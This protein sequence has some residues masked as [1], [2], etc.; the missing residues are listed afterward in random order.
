MSGYAERRGQLLAAFGERPRG[1]I[2]LAKNTSNL[3]RDRARAGKHLLDV[4]DFDHVLAIDPAGHW[5]EAEGMT[6]YEDLAARTLA[7]GVMPAVVPQLKT[8][9]LGGAAAGVGIEASSFRHGLVHESLLEMDVLTGDGRVLT[10]TPDNEHRDLFFGFPNSYGTL[11]Y[12]LKLRA[13]TV[14][15]K[16]FVELHH[17]RFGEPQAF[18]A[19]LEEACSQSFDFVDGVVFDQGTLV[20]STA[21]FVES[22]PYSS[23]YTFERIFYR[24]LLEREL[25]YLSAHDFLW[26]WD[27]DWFWCSKNVGAQVPWIR[28]I[29][30][31]KR[32]GSRTYQAVMRWNSRWGVTRALGRLRGLHSESV[33]QDVDIPVGR[34]AEFLEFFQRDIGI[35]PVWICPVQASARADRFCLYPLRPDALYVNFGFWDVVRTSGEHS[36]GFFNRLVEHEVEALGGIKSLYSDSYYPPEHFWRIYGGNA[37]RALKARYDPGGNFPDLY[38]KCVLRH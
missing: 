9:T 4:R 19:A 28:R 34:A 25:D 33:I 12:A 22:A 36:A 23:D 30:G 14:P 38:S 21:R 20:L 15:V 16:A 29:Y 26:R 5:V 10:C 6:S 1:S 17:R 7:A 32:L 35:L 13:R 24:S 11:G 37:Y 18:F 31:R 2:G 27:T 8:I 3:F